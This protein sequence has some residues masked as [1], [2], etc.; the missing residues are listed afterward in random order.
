MEFVCRVG[1]PEGK[2][3][4]EVHTAHDERSLQRDLE[5]RG[6]HIFDI[7]RRGLLANLRRAAPGGRRNRIAPQSLLLFNQELA[8][9]LRS[10]LPVLQS[11][12][13]MAD[14]ERDPFFREVL[15]S[16]RDQVESGA[17]LSRA[18][19]SFGALV[20]PLY[21]A[22]LA[23]GERTGEL[24][25]VIRR[26]VRYQQ[27]VME[28]RK[29]VVTALVYPTVLIGLSLILIGVMTFYVVPKFTEF[30]DA[31]GSELPLLT[32]MIVGASLFVRDNWL[33]TLVTLAVAA[34]AVRQWKS[35]PGGELTVDRL[36]LRVPLLGGVF[37][38]M[39]M[40]E[41]C[42]SLSTLLSGGIP[43]VQ[44]LDNS[45]AAIGNTWIRRLVAP[46]TGQVREGKPLHEALE[47]TGVSPDIATDMIKVGEATGALDEMLANASDFLDQEVENRMQRIMS[48]LEPVM[49]VLMGTIVTLLLVA[50]YL[51]LFSLLGQVQA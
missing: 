8:A 32:R 7:R 43:V 25:Q 39:A 48:L 2:V 15:G 1:T 31:L 42:R 45:V 51:P 11:L 9:L 26:F 46:V 49:L 30:F 37:H 35:S 24:E 47:E 50:I 13:M 44:A 29:R 14:R 23:A 3:V 34:M 17:D 18:F 28:A 41:F 6:Y 38:R 16:I 21:P 19:A 5:G 36:K 20:P 22:T 27:L 33:L 4:E 10:G 40:S 12:R